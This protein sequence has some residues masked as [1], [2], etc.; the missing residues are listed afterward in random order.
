MRTRRVIFSMGL[1]LV[2][3]L[4][5]VAYLGVRRGFSARDQPSAIEAFV[6]SRMRRLSLP[7]SAVGARNPIPL[8]PSVLD[9]GRGHFADHCAVCHG[10]DG[11][12]NT[13]MGRNLYPK[14]PDLRSPYTQSLSDGEI[15]YIIQ[16]GVRLSGMP[17]WGS[18][19][20]DEDNWKL[21]HFIRHLPKVTPEE[22]RAME[23]LNPKSADEHKEEERNHRRY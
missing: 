14:A 4:A 1:L 16:N 12:G 3:A 5:L 23:A 9:D 22:I 13:E 6:A 10:N 18:S 21:V 17:A 2:G 20:D 19:H 15:Y 11:S 7:S 8:T